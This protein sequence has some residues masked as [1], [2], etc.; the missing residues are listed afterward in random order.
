MSIERQKFGRL[1]AIRRIK[2]NSNGAYWLCVC[3]CG[4]KSRVDQWRL[5]NGYTTS[6][7]CWRAEKNTVLPYYARHAPLSFLQ[8]LGRDETAAYKS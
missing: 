3:D 4:N 1:R 5:K 8:V 2:T 7:G 6:C